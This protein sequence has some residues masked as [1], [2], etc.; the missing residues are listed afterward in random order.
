M[1]KRCRITKLLQKLQSC[2][3]FHYKYFA[4]WK[5]YF[6]CLQRSVCNVKSKY[7]CLFLQCKGQRILLDTLLTISIIVI[8]TSVSNIANVSKNG[9]LMQHQSFNIHK[10]CFSC[11]LLS[12]YASSANFC[13]RAVMGVLKY[14]K[15]P[16]NVQAGAGMWKRMEN[17]LG[18]EGN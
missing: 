10:C 13:M 15:G 4:L 6:L 18:E 17:Q 1:R 2:H 8:G 5:Y 11:K 9:S 3:L 7:F 16:V 12:E 14:P